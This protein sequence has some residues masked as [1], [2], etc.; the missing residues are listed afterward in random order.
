V[1]F[2]SVKG[3]TEQF[4]IRI[5]KAIGC[6]VVFT[7]HNLLPHEVE[8]VAEG[9]SDESIFRLVHRVVVHSEDNR[10]E[11]VQ[12]F[13]L[14]P[15]RIAVIPHGSYDLLLPRGR[16]P[17]ERARAELGL[18]RDAKVILFFGLIR[19]Y[20]GLEFL[21]EAFERLEASHP[22]AL[23]LIVGEVF[24]GDAEDHAFY[25]RLVEEA[26]RR[27]NVR[28]VPRYVPIGDVASYLSA[29]EIVVLPYAKTYQS[30]VLFAA[31]AAGR[32]VIV[33]ETGGLPETVE[34][35]KTGL[36]VPPRD[37]AALA[38]AIASLLERPSLAEEMGRNAARL[39]D[40]VYSWDEI[41][42]ATVALYESLLGSGPAGG[43]RVS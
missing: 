4:L 37:S 1:H 12:L 39:A 33:T 20:K 14:P 9:D 16:T 11:L 32:P 30:G 5:L 2:Q 36:V 3:G 24:R 38:R 28:C 31:Y 22:D 21:V 40:T 27:R 15:E 18:D 23:L 41:A 10:Q 13:G 34:D 29:A 42:K 8:S 26:S 17:K 19:R 6:R 35:G 43:S 7:A 25:S